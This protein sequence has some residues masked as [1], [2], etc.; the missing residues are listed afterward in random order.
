MSP[1]PAPRPNPDTSHTTEKPMTRP[2]RTRPAARPRLRCARGHFLPAGFRP[3]GDPDT[4]DDTC[5]CKPVS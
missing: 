1:V 4:W 5:R 2:P 3:H